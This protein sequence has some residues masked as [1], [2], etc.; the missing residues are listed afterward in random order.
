MAQPGRSLA[1]VSAPSPHI[2][3]D[4]LPKLTVNFLTLVVEKCSAR[5]RQALQEDEDIVDLRLRKQIWNEILNTTV[6]HLESVFGDTSVPSMCR[7]F[8]LIIGNSCC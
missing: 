8:L 4:W 2:N 1:T 6:F 5:T 3:P 7:V